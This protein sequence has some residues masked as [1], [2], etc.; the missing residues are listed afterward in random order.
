LLEACAADRWSLDDGTYG[1]LPEVAAPY[2]RWLEWV[3]GT[4]HMRFV[5]AKRTA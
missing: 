5:R 4:R 1:V 2:W 3:T